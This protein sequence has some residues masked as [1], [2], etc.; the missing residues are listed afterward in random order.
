MSKL[1]MT[2]PKPVKKQSLTM[3]PDQIQQLKQLSHEQLSELV[4]SIYGAEKSIDKTIESA[5]LANDPVAL[6][7]HLKK[8]IQS[9]GR[10][11]RFIGYRESHG[12]SFEL[13]QLVEEITKLLPTDPKATFALTDAFMNIHGKVLDR[14]DDSDGSVGDIFRGT[15]QLWV[16]AAAAWQASELPCKLNWA[17]EVTSRHND[18][19]YGMWDNLVSLSLPVLG[20]QTLR[21]L[22][23]QF[24]AEL[25][26]RVQSSTDRFDST[27]SGAQHG[28]TG[29]AEALADV[30]MYER[31]YTIVKAPNEL[32]KESIAVFCLR[33]GDGDAALKWLSGSWDNRFI[34]RRQQ[35]LDEVY[36]MMGRHDDLLKLRRENY[37]KEPGYEN[38]QALLAVAPQKEQSQLKAKASSMASAADCPSTAIHTLLQLQDYEAVSAYVLQNPDKLERLSYYTL[39][40]WAGTFETQGLA[41]PAVIAYRV[42]LLDILESGR[43]KAYR[44]AAKYYKALERLHDEVADYQ[45][46]PDS[47]GFH[48]E[49]VEKHGLKRSFWALVG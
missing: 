15:V 31:A 22:A 6:V 11:S 16:E 9:I 19:G 8:R 29:A 10:G 20:E 41:L 44:Y 1:A 45:K 21:E 32:Q 33:V 25:S 12:F 14:C 2:S 36:R 43:S 26:K 13:L 47:A 23:E 49:L 34:N 4:I 39:A 38:L 7:K 5:L 24:E 42:L 35:L 28:M 30:S 40:E 46:W 17:K 48:A 27:I 3:Q 18:N 37:N